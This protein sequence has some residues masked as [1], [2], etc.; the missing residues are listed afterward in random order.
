MAK[1]K[2]KEPAEKATAKRA[3]YTWPKLSLPKQGRVDTT[4]LRVMRGTTASL[5]VALKRLASK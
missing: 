4:S 1:V 2:S 5:R 3:K